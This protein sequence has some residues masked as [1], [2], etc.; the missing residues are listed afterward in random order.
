M[1]S[2]E[3]AMKLRPIV[4]IALGFGL[5]AVLSAFGLLRRRRPLSRQ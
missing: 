1:D 2:R 4:Y 5:L 3:I